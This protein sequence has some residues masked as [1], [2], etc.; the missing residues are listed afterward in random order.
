M[1][2][3][4]D[5]CPSDPINPLLLLLSARTN[6]I[7]HPTVPGHNLER[8]RVSGR[9]LRPS[10][11]HAIP[12]R[13]V[14]HPSAFRHHRHVFVQKPKQ[15][16]LLHHEKP[17]PPRLHDLALFLQPSGFLVRRL[18]ILHPVGD[19]SRFHDL[20]YLRPE[21]RKHLLPIFILL[22]LFSLSSYDSMC[23][24][25]PLARQ[26]AISSSVNFS[27]FTIV[28]PFTLFFVNFTFPS[29]KLNKVWS[30]PIPQFSPGCHFVPRCLAMMFPGRTSSPPYFLMPKNFGFESRPFDVDPPAFFDA[31]LTRCGCCGCS[32]PKTTLN[33]NKEDKV[34]ALA[35]VLKLFVFFKQKRSILIFHPQGERKKVFSHASLFWWKR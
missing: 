2:S 11:R 23:L 3:P 10:H 13:C 30:V 20:R 7:H 27:I 16:P 17:F 12:T 9:L 34:V 25:F 26:S 22:L 29:T 8:V 6:K 15:F 4:N 21:F 32:P 24:S 31:N 18:P 14:D 28:L 33:D 5:D 19:D 1:S 35:L